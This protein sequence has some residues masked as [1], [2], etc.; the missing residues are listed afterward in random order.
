ME[1]YLQS[2]ISLTIQ[3]RLPVLI[4]GGPGTG[5][6]SF[7]NQVAHELGVPI[8]TI[9]ASIREP[10]DFGGLP[11]VRKDG[12]AFEPPAWAKR[13]ASIEDEKGGI[14]FIDEISTTPPAVQAALLRV[15]HEGV[16]GDITLPKTIAK[17]AAANPPEQAAGGWTLAPPLA[18]RFVHFEWE[19]NFEKWADGALHGWSADGY[20]PILPPNW[21]DR[22][23][24]AMALVSSYIRH[25]PA[26]L[27]QIPQHEAEAGKAWASPR[28][29]EMAAILMAAANAAGVSEDVR[30]TMVSGAIG[31]STA[32]EFINWTNDLDLPDPEWLL[33]HPEKFKVPSRQ[34]RVYAVLSSVLTATISKVTKERWM[35][36]WAIL[37]KAAKDKSPDIAAFAARTLISKVDEHS[38]LPLPKKEIAAFAPILKEIN[39]L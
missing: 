4:W 35:A 29:W 24:D 27:Y 33:K 8:E 14:L 28:T 7:V 25:R 13:L 38:N 32:H 31:P 15:I 30:V 18:N 21:R 26:H 6:T 34:D 5:K 11:V 2:A 16:V 1:G 20:V 37:A 12:V 3:T 22:I 23:P 36:C 9:I 19:T 17:V 39:L 10:S